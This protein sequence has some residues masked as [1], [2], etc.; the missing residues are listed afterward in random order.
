M[1]TRFPAQID[2]FPIHIPQEIIRSVHVNDLQEAIIAIEV[3]SKALE[4][5][6]GN[7]TL[8]L[9]AAHK[10][11]AIKLDVFLNGAENVLDSLNNL[12]NKINNHVNQATAAH[13]ATSISVAAI[14]LLDTTN[15]QAALEDLKAKIDLVEA[16]NVDNI[17]LQNHLNQDINTAHSGLILGTKIASSQ[18]GVGHLSFD[19]A[20]QAELNAHTTLDKSTAHPGT[21]EN[22]DIAVGTI[23]ED[24]LAFNI[25]TQAELDAHT[26]A[27]MN[28]HGIGSNS[29]VVGTKTTQILENKTLVSDFSGSKTLLFI[30]DVTDEEK[31]LYNSSSPSANQIEIRKKA[32]SLITNTN[33]LG[34]VS[35][36]TVPDSSLF[37]NIVGIANGIQFWIPPSMLTTSATVTS[38]PDGTTLIL[39]SLYPSVNTSNV[40]VNT[41]NAQPL[42]SV[43]PTGSVLVKELH[44][45]DSAFSDINFNDDVT[46]VGNL[47]VTETTQLQA[48]VSITGNSA[49]SGSSTVGTFLTVGTSVTTSQLT[50]TGNASIGNNLTVTN[51]LTVGNNQTIVGSLS[52]Q[53]NVSVDGYVTIDQD[54]SIAGGLTVGNFLTAGTGIYSGGP[55]DVAGDT[56]LAQNLQVGA[57]LYVEGNTN[58][59]GYL[60]VIEDVNFDGIL[61]VSQNT[62]LDGYATV[63]GSLTV[64]GDLLVSGS[65]LNPPNVFSITNGQV[66]AANIPSLNFGLSTRGTFV[67]YTIYRYHTGPTTE[68]AATG[69]LRAINKNVA[70]IWS[71][72][73]T[74]VGDNVGVTFT[75]DATGQVKYT[76]TSIAGSLVSSVMKF[77]TRSIDI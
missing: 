24:R 36:I 59:D 72:D 61:H 69:T 53:D 77:R 20:T 67:E 17:D 7:H 45:E 68:L 23:T 74:Y 18:I 25:A 71:L 32:V 41:V 56:N 31:L 49:V 5:S 48:G 46:I 3:F 19:P 1:T 6:L 35:E 54:A 63:G 12:N 50:T 58:I 11:S 15:L 21:I 75:I 37:A 28:V 30:E 70:A 4:E 55:L 39:N 60:H 73:D 51:N 64:S 38:I 9:E 26:L 57:D 27:S 76:S 65:I 52:V 66:V 42:F 47:T 10:A 29:S 34:L 44:V 43:S 40:A 14:P 62:I 8:Q 16:N 33:H 13:A 2:S 22:A